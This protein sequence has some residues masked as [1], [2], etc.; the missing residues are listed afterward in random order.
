MYASK[1]QA[2]RGASAYAPENTLE[3]FALA[4]D[5]KADGIELD[6]HATADGYIV[7]CHD[8]NIKRTSDGEGNIG[9]MTLEQL[10]KYDFSNRFH[11]K[12]GFCRIPLLSEVYELI[13]PTGMF[14][15]VELKDA[16]EKFV[17]TV[18]DLEDEYKMNGR[19]IY[20]SFIHD[21]FK[22]LLARKPNA[23][24]APL[25]SS[26]IEKPWEYALKLHSKALH[27]HFS[28]VLS[29]P[30]YVDEC[31]K[32]GIQVN[33]WTADD[34]ETITALYKLGVDSVIT[35]V[36]DVALGLRNG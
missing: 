13:K 33:P 8:G 34:P 15:N 12:Y 6:V 28:H 31:H 30:G 7:V 22:Y 25:Y 9:E 4:V 16:G 23:Y 1:I 14:V 3:A 24:T 19:V 29:V 11:D 20:S 26:E 17:N 10:R 32:R 5:M 2:H 18:L 36:P 21:S 27:P 35:N